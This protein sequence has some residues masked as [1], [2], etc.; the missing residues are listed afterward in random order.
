MTNEANFDMVMPMNFLFHDESMK[1]MSQS[2]YTNNTLTGMSGDYEVKYKK[3][4]EEIL[5]EEDANKVVNEIN[6][7]GTLKKV[8]EKLNYTLLLSD[9][10]MKWDSVTR[11]FVSTG[12]IGVGSIG[13]TQINKYVKGYMQIIKKRSG[14][15]FN[16]YFELDDKE[17]YFF[18]Y[19]NNMMMGLSSIKEFNDFII[20]EKPDKRRLDAGGGLPSYSYYISSERK[21]DK[22]LETM[23]SA[24]AGDNGTEPD[25]PE[26]K[27]E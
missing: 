18:S 23:K 2:M 4:L 20:K 1:M 19:A 7:Y 14:D 6:L 27:T 26:P 10:K 22:F 25:A 16:L 8:P 15:A 11:S 9:I 21:K 5:G 17:W 24:G 12:N 13:K 3:A